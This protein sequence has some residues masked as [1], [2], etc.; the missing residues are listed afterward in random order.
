MKTTAALKSTITPAHAAQ[1]GFTLIELMVALVIGLFLIGGLLTL[2]GGMRRTTT[3]QSGMSQLQDNERMAMTLMADVIQTTGYFPN[4]ITNTASG[5]FLITAPF[6]YPG[7]ALS[8]AGSYAAAAPGDT[9]TVRYMTAG[10]DGV[11]NCTGAT[12]TVAAIFVNTFSVDTSGDLN[13]GLSTTIG[14]TT[15]VS[16]VQLISGQV[17]NGVVVSG[18]TKLQIYYGVATN[19]SVNTNSVDT[20]LDAAQVAAGNYWPYVI[21]VQLKLTFVNPLSGQPGQTSTTIPFTR[22]VV[23][24]N[25]AGITT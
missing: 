6:T 11:I 14:G 1:R 22:T 2:L 10:G 21:S 20:Y 5:L 15:T 12:S 17:V 16:T 18:V 13:C 23:V 7:Q 8:G 9:V 25:K 4:P 19:T 24:M 3:T